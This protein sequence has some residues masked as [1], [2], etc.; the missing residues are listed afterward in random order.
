M[1]S[2]GETHARQVDLTAGSSHVSLEKTD[3]SADDRQGL[4]GRHLQ[5]T[6]HCIHGTG[7]C[8]QETECRR[9]CRGKDLV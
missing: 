4:S 2:P 1:T 8:G 9:G 7:V 6:S 3:L 5:E